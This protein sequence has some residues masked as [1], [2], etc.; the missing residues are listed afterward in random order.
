MIR[1]VFIAIFSAV[2]V[3]L[4]LDS[5]R[6]LK[7]VSLIN[8]VTSSAPKFW[9]F[10]TQ[11]TNFVLQPM[12]KILLKL[13]LV[14]TEVNTTSM[15][16][17]H[18]DWDFVWS[19]EYISF[20]PFNY[21]ALKPYQRINH[22]PGIGHLTSKSDL[23]T[24]TNSKY[25]PNGFKNFQDLKAFADKN[26]NTRFV[27]KLSTNRG[28]SLKNVS[29]VTFGSELGSDGSFAQVFVENPLLI[30]GHKFDFNIF[31]AITSV[32]PV[33]VYYYEKN[34]HFR[35]CPLPYD[36]NNFEDTRSYVIDESHIPGSDFPEMQKYFNNSYSFKEAF[37]EIMREKGVDTKVIYDQVEDCIQSVIMSKEQL[38]LKE[39]ERINPKYGKVHFFELVR[40]DFLI[41]ANLKLNLM[42]VN[43]SPNLYANDKI[44]NNQ[45]L[46]ESVIYNYL[47]LVGVGTYVGT[48]NHIQE[49]K[50]DE[51]PFLC[52]N[53]G[54]TVNIGV[55]MGNICR[56]FCELE[57]CELCLHC[58]SRSMLWDVKMAYLEH[59][60]IGEMK[61]VVPPSNV[62]ISNWEN[63]VKMT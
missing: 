58:L 32:N 30:N 1:L 24:Y 27:Q 8:V 50:A 35:F 56:E 4:L 18:D 21:S 14:K 12:E 40:F 46:F 2:A 23:A 57:V 7:Q 28:V 60:N 42:E 45:P 36:P 53:D 26:P 61:R 17:M 43:L 52:N 59:L 29:E 31:V 55:C 3:N 37:D 44:I 63:R 9:L 41:D 22:I 11:K 16:T 15:E 20:I 49:F 62:I 13:G 19:F 51:E 47:N 48:K 10:T 38:M 33:R 34:Y 5:S 25:V 39:I 54:I 6:E